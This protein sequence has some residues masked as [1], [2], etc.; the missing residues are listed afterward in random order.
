ME[1]NYKMLQPLYRTAKKQR[2]TFTG[3]HILESMCTFF[4][5]KIKDLDIKIESSDEFNNYEFFTYE[6]VIY[7]VFINIINNALYWLI[8]STNRMIRIEYFQDSQE[9]LIM[10]NGEKIDNMIIDDIFTLFFTRK[11]NGRGIGLYLAKQSLKSIGMDIYASNASH[12]NRLDGASFI[13]KL[14]STL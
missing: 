12:Y 11:H 8:P 7:S 9:I 5:Q 3:K 4:S 6:S 2:T 14:T 10:N 13:I 1:A